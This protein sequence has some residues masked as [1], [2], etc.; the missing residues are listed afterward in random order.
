MPFPSRGVPFCGGKD[1]ALEESV[2]VGKCPINPSNDGDKHTTNA[3]ALEPSLVERYLCDSLSI[4][5]HL[6]R[7]TDYSDICIHIATHNGLKNGFSIWNAG[8]PFIARKSGP[9]KGEKEPS[10]FI[11]IRQMIEDPG[12]GELRVAPSVVRLQSLDSCYGSGIHTRK[13]LA[14]DL[15]FERSLRR[16]D[17][18]RIVFIGN[19]VRSKHKFAYQIIESRSQVLDAISNNE[20]E[21]QGRIC[22]DN[23]PSVNDPIRR[24]IDIG[25][26]MAGVGF[27]IP[28]HFGHEQ[29][30]M[31]FS[32]DDFEACGV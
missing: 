22:Y 28:V 23:Q 18:E 9:Q 31:L 1:T 14:A 6:S 3:F 25:Q 8:K 10:V 7:S 11:D 17:R 30:Q 19:A 20:G 13:T 16:A 2:K 32:P 5:P 24:R 15:L 29:F 4:R 27:E 26:E 12:K 21:I